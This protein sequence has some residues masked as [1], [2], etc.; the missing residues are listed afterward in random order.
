MLGERAGCAE[1]IESRAVMRILSGLG[2]TCLAVVAVGLMFSAYQYAMSQAIH[3]VIASQ[4]P[5]PK[6]ADPPSFTEFNGCD[7]GLTLSQSRPTR[8]CRFE[9]NPPPVTPVPIPEM[10][11]ADSETAA[12]W[13]IFAAL[14][15]PLALGGAAVA[16]LCVLKDR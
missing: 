16:G 5:M 11:K 13:F 3:A 6:L 15:L 2:R 1:Q 4:P 8:P 10:S 7:L 14:A 12:L 9:L